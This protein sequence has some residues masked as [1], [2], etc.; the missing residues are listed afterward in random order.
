MN[1]SGDGDGTGADETILFATAT[2]DAM[3]NFEGLVS[4]SQPNYGGAIRNLYLDGNGKA[5]K[6]IVINSVDKVEVAFVTVRNILVG[7]IETTTKF[8][9]PSAQHNRVISCKLYAGVSGYGL[10]YTGDLTGGS[11]ASLNYAEDNYIT[12]T[13][14]DAVHFGFS[15]GNLLVQCRVHRGGSGRGVVFD[16]DDT[17]ND[18]HA[19]H[20]TLMHPQLGNSSGVYA[21]AGDGTRPS[22]SNS[23]VSGST[24]NG[25]LNI[26]DITI[27]DGAEFALTRT[28]EG[29]YGTFT[30]TIAGNSVAGV[31]TYSTNKGWYE[32]KGQL[33][34]FVIEIE[35]TAKDVATSGSLRIEGL[36][37][38]AKV[39][40]AKPIIRS[41]ADIFKFSITG[42]DLNIIGATQN[43]T[44]YLN[45]SKV[46]ANLGT[47]VSLVAGNLG[48]D[49]RIIIHGQYW[50]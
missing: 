2:M 11:N 28:N 33:V 16:A 46:E 14:G 22:Q 31:Q 3:V 38:A 21:L 19:R 8:T 32:V 48:N 10:L 27:E 49:T 43:A 23:I 47:E 9:F 30:P 7:C 45:L 42:T 25:S 12:I 4:G 50:Y 35:M 29:R 41:S 39:E 17:G 34:T 44:N 24:G 40:T 5:D 13:D 15:D 18:R 1:G 37:F 36:P 6:G 26:D 20:N